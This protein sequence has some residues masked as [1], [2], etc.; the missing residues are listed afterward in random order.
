MEGEAMS[1]FNIYGDVITHQEEKRQRALTRQAERSYRSDREQLEYLVDR[2]HGFCR[3]ARELRDRL[4]DVQISA[5]HT[6]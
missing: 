6:N 3:E 2:G 4:G 1:K 5:L